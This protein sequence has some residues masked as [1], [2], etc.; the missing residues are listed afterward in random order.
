M[1][2]ACEAIC[3]FVK[4]V[5][6]AA[7]HHLVWLA[8]GTVRDLLLHRQQKDIDL[9]VA[10][11]AT[12]LELLGF[13]PV[14]AKTAG[15]IWF[16]N[17][18]SAGKVEITRIDAAAAVS[19][20]L[21]RRDFT[22][23]AML[24]SLD[25]D[26]IDPLGGMDDLEARQIRPCSDACFSD[27]PLRIFRAFRFVA[28]GFFLAGDAAGR[29]RAR[30]WEALL[31][32]LPVERFSGEMLKALAAPQ[33]QNFFRDMI[34]FSV[35]NVWLPELFRMPLV[36]AGP[37]EHHPE[38]DLFCH[39]SEVLER[40]ASV[41]DDPL[42]RFCAFFHDIGKLATVPANYPHHSGH[43]EAGY[44]A[45]VQFCRRL[46]LP[47]KYGMALALIS[48]L[49]GKINKI[50]SMRPATKLGMAEQAIRGGV[51]AML[52]VI[53]AAD[54]DGA[55]LSA[56]WPAAVAVARMN[57][58]ELGIDTARLQAMPPAQRREIIL[59]RRVTILKSL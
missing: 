11:P 59:Q 55:E 12:R 18:P 39:A 49:H 29:I 14:T 21:R 41:A 50:G 54:K 34:A 3:R 30:D 36:P 53:A 23:N 4:G 58:R 1:N 27:D 15:N 9:L 38:G 2:A 26:L 28:E 40:A 33:P 25:G 24:L 17:F 16:R 47:N 13:R 57:S 8:G 19:D 46:A 7:A 48:R 10:L 31:Q 51:D 44:R 56:A 52:P 5:F 45:A 6:P 43:E 22:M 35:G 32:L 20:D 42:T 37:R